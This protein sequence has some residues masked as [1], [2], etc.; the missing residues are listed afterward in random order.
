MSKNLQ[1]HLAL[2]LVAIIYASNYVVAKLVMPA[3]VLPFAFIIFRVVGATL[4]FWILHA[5][6]LREKVQKKSDYFRFAYCA[7][8]GVVINQLLFFKGLSLTSPINASIILTISPIVVLIAAAIILKEKITGLKVLGIILGAIGAVSI[9]ILSNTSQV[10]TGNA[11]GDTL[12]LINACS[13]SIYLVLVKP[14]MLRYKALTVVKWVFF[15]ACFTVIPFGWS[16][17][18]LIDWQN[19]P[20]FA[21][22]IIA[23]VIVAV[24][25]GVY[26]LNAFA[27][28]YV[29]ASIVGFYIY[30]QPVLTSLIAVS[31]GQDSLTWEKIA[32]S[33][34]IFA[35]VYLVNV[36]VKKKSNI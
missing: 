9:I 4:L 2:F 1:V 14:L 12:V 16:E 13:Y 28:Q 7:L 25:F 11:W 22:G 27:L 8:F 3:Y 33:M 5:L 30:L 6:T 31:F 34:L 26:L 35:G 23:F 32:F 20:L 17:M 24:T 10:A 29:N 18:Q 15:F 36:P 19:L 21:I